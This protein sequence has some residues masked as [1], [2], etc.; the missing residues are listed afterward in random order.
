MHKETDFIECKHNNSNIGIDFTYSDNE[1]R[2][3]YI[4]SSH[5]NKNF[6]VTYLRSLDDARKRRLRDYSQ[7][8]KT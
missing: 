1:C 7:K 4:S 3:L 2:T 6:L 8:I 5:N